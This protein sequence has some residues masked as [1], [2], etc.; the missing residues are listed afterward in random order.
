[1]S[2]AIKF[3][4]FVAPVALLAL[5]GCATGLPTQVSRFQQMPAPAG[6]TF[7]IE[8]A[9]A[10]NRSGIEFSRYADLV[11]QALT[12]E[13]FAP[14]GSAEQASLRV[15]MDYGVDNGRAEVR[16]SPGFY[17]SR[18][19]G[20]GNFG[21]FGGRPY[22]SRFGYYGGRRSAFT[23]GYD[24][25]FLYGGFGGGFGGFDDIRSYTV[26][27]S[28]LDVD[29]RG[30]DGR[31]LFEGSVKA[32]SRSDDLQ[33]LVPNLVEAMFTGFPGRSGENV[34]ITVQPPERRR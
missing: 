2:F 13:G 25:P 24:D 7:F 1:M 15:S 8:A 30:R 32:R 10:R 17:G 27:T 21:R 28:F 29:I 12:A 16:S 23:Y 20:F 34:R 18:Y 3:L 4:G 6:Q 11:S 9:D 31:S 33:A 26:Y 19:G 5:S 14:A 22:Y